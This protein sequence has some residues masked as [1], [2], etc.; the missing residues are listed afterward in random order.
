MSSRMYVVK[1][2]GEKEPV[3]FDKIT[4]RIEKL[5]V[6]LNP[7]Y[8]DPVRAPPRARGRNF[9]LCGRCADGGA[10]AGR[11]GRGPGVGANPRQNESCGLPR[12]SAHARPAPPLRPA[13]G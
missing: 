1:R 5:C 12:D 13:P 8:V 9:G 7:E 6:G 11:V 3:K 10:G 2:N 4:A